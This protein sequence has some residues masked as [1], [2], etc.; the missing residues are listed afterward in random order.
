MGTY[1][2]AVLTC[3]QGHT[4]LSHT[5]RM[6]LVRLEDHLNT[7]EVTLAD[8]AQGLSLNSLTLSK[9]CDFPQERS[10][11]VQE[12]MLFGSEAAIWQGKTSEYHVYYDAAVRRILRQEGGHSL[13]PEAF[14]D[15]MAEEVMLGQ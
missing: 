2:A 15:Q 5:H 13:D 3:S 6:S 7:W 8:I 14:Q 12:R 4:T 9:L 1:S 11:G 10:R